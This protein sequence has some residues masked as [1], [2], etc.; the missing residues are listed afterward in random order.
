MSEEQTVGVLCGVSQSCDQVSVVTGHP[1]R[2]LVSLKDKQGLG[3]ST[4]IP[5][6]NNGL[7]NYERYS[8][9]VSY[10][11]HRSQSPILLKVTKENVFIVERS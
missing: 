5:T 9:F 4:S 6:P 3:T 7:L 1:G 2:S 8:G 11:R 10:T